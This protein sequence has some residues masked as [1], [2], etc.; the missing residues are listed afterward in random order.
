M[1]ASRDEVETRRFLV[2]GFFSFLRSRKVLASVLAGSCLVTVIGSIAFALGLPKSISSFSVPTRP[3]TNSPITAHWVTPTNESGAPEV[4]MPGGAVEGRG[5]FNAISCPTTTRCIAVGGDKSLNGVVST[6]NNGGSSWT[7]DV[8]ASGLPELNAVSCVSATNCVAVGNGGVVTSA[9]GGMTWVPHTI[10]TANTS[11]LGINC[12][13]STTC[14]S[15]GVSPGDAGPY[16]G[17][18]LVSVNGGVT[19][20]TPK[21]PTSIGALGSVDCPSS[22]FCVA[23]GAQILVSDDGGKSWSPRFVNGGTGILRSV[24]CSSTTTCVAIGSNPMGVT[25]ASA[26]AFGVITVDGGATWSAVPMP[27]R[28]WM[29]NAISCSSDDACATSG[30]SPNSVAFEWTSPNGGATWSSQTLPAGVTAVSSI[31]CLS[32]S[33]C[34]FVGLQGSQPVSGVSNDGS[35]WNVTAATSVFATKSATS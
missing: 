17:Q 25:D 33:H 9:D 11:L 4:P 19:W 13:S 21:L 15:V 12:T 30:P 2:V 18:V 16:G 3:P 28:S 35:T 22:T 29:I 10:P 8:V 26:S 1:V 31:Y 6:S 24:A 14:M 34:V 32:L 23:V 5:S 27:A 20:V 7:A